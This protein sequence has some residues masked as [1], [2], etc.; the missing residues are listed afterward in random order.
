MGSREIYCKTTQLLDGNRQDWEQKCDQ[1]IWY[2]TS[3]S[4][5]FGNHEEIIFEIGR[6]KLFSLEIERANFAVLPRRPAL[7][8]QENLK[9]N[10]QGALLP[11]VGSPVQRDLYD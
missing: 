3:W 7:M 8:T 2:K 11:D 1:L 9:L 5:L 6:P 4:C 10:S